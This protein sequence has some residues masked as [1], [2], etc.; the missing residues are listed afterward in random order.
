MKFRAKASAHLVDAIQFLGVPNLPKA[1]DF[2]L[3][4]HSDYSH[5]PVN[6]AFAKR[7][8]AFKTATMQLEIPTTDGFQFCDPFDMIVRDADGKFFP[9]KPVAFVQVYDDVPVI[10]TTAVRE[11]CPDC[12]SPVGTVHDMGC[13]TGSGTLI[14]SR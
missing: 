2:L 14:G 4:G 12:T 13:K 1:L 5:L 11:T 9:M 3:D 7:G 8:I 10:E 6:M